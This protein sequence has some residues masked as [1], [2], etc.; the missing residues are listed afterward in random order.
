MELIAAISM[1]VIVA[2][3]VAA[4]ISYSIKIYHNESVNTALQ[5]EIQTNINQ[6]LDT[7]MSSSGVVIIQGAGKTDLAGF[8]SFK[9][10]RD[11]SGNVTAVDFTGVVLGSGDKNPSSGLFDIYLRRVTAEHAANAQAAVQSAATPFTNPTADKKPYLLGQN[12]KV[13]NITM[14]TD[15]TKSSCIVKTW[16]SDTDP[17]K[18]INPLLVDVELEFEKDG[19]GKKINKR[20]QDNAIMRNH[21]TSDIWIDGKRYVLNKN[22]GD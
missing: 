11:L 16:V 17:G 10:T 5:Y 3:S 2:A 13:F 12:A 9:E 1:G 4:L 7:I 18:Y 15:V 19:T 14:N 21:V 8:G 6:V 20:V 22:T